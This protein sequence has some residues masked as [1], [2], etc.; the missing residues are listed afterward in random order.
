[1]T[2]ISYGKNPPNFN[3]YGYYVI[4]TEWMNQWNGF[5]SGKHTAPG[6]IDNSNLAKKIKDNRK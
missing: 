1:M 2:Q 3:I 6:I 4:S 5:I